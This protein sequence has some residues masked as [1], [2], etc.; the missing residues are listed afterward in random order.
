MKS[1]SSPPATPD[2]F[3]IITSIWT[4]QE[5]APTVDPHYIISL[6]EPGSKYLIPTGP[7][8]RKHLRL[9]M[10]DIDNQGAPVPPPYVAPNAMRVRQIIDAA[11]TWERSS[12]VL[13]HCVA[14]VSRSGAAGLVFLAARNPGREREVALRLRQEGPW[15]NPNPSIVG[16]GDD[17]LGL[18]GAL[19]RALVEMGEP[20]TRSVGGA[21]TVP[22][23]I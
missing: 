9:D 21:V 7:A 15:L 19:R 8:L 22:M 4:A 1:L 23:T 3:V 5:I 12:I 17:L 14:G 2:G 18:Q 6:G 13:I 20:T 16:L 11:L 10:H